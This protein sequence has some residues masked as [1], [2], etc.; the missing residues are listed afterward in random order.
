MKGRL[1]G[2][3]EWLEL[4]KA[5]MQDGND[6]IAKEE[7]DRMDEITEI[8]HNIVGSGSKLFIDRKRYL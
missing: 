7:K 4:H 8:L 3:R 6:V 5:Q 2:Y 1:D